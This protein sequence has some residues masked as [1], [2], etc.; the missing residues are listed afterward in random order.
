[1]LLEKFIYKGSFVD[2]G[3][4]FGMTDFSMGSMRF[5]WNEN[6]LNRNTFLKNLCG[7][8]KE[9]A[10]LELIHSKI[11][12][13]IKD[14]SELNLKQGDGIITRN[15]NLVPVVTVA[16]CVPIFIFDVLSKTFGALHSGW[17]GTGIV[18]QAIEILEKK[19]SSK[20]SDIC[21]A[22]GPHIGSCC[23]SVTEE[24][25][26]YFSENFS[27]DCVEK[28]SDDKYSLSLTKAN[29]A[30]L[31]KH[32]IPEDN[33]KV[34]DDCT[35]CCKKEGKNVY[36]S[37]RR[38]TMNAGGNRPHGDKSPEELSKMFT[39]QAAFVKWDD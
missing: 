30:V 25:A 24:R 4:V 9:P 11:V 36:G 13:D 8:D 29:L 7:K 3:P 23:Y 15:K 37:F 19:Y 5:R 22:I 10:A 20:P 26:K 14:S 1:M 33:I 28:I 32:S 34:I 16:D 12:F 38:Q 31:K 39:V 2:D 27:S 17:K 21:V 18:G 35:C 6:N